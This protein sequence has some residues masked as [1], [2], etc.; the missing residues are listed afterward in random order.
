M[1]L[2][3]IVRRRQPTWIR[4][5]TITT[6]TTLRRRRRCRRRMFRIHARCLVSPRRAHRASAVCL[7]NAVIFPCTYSRGGKFTDATAGES[8]STRSVSSQL[9]VRLP[10]SL[11]AKRT[12][13]QSEEE[14]A[15]SK[16]NEFP[17][18]FFRVRCP[19]QRRD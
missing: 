16:R 10:A 6:R 5:T 12:V 19:L 8:S 3:S 9:R 15:V 11:E 1:A 2:L 7:H 14:G 18:R 4:R 17:S 13:Q